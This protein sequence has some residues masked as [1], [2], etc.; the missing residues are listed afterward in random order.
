MS[1]P[2]DPPDRV[3]LEPNDSHADFLKAKLALCFTFAEIAETN[4]RIGHS[5]SADSAMSKAQK[6]WATATRLL[7]DPDH[8]KH[9]TDGEI[10]NI[11]TELERLRAKIDGLPHR[12]K[13]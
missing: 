8:A 5:E 6:G 10:Q 2:S 4:F 13:K 7:S 1:V 11:N 12:F 3:Q 9:L